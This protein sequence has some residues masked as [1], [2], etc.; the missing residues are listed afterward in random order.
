MSKIDKEIKSIIH[1]D[2]L[3]YN[4]NIRL[5]A[6]NGQSYK[7]AVYTKSKPNRPTST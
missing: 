1:Q 7:A 3:Q 5:T 6:G 2:L 4:K